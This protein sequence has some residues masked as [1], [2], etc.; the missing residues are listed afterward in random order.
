MKKVLTVSVLLMCHC[1]VFANEIRVISLDEFNGTIVPEIKKSEKLIRNLEME[2]EISG[3]QKPLNSASAD[4]KDSGFYAKVKLLSDGQQKG[5][6]KINVFNEKHGTR[7]I[8][9]KSYELSYNGKQGKKLFHGKSLKDKTLE[10]KEC[11]ILSSRS[12]TIKSEMAAG[13]YG[14]P[15]I[16]NFLAEGSNPSFS[17]Y[18]KMIMDP[19][20]EYSSEFSRNI[21][22]VK[23]ENTE[24][25]RIQI[26]GKGVVRT[27]YWLDPA[28]N[29]APLASETVQWNKSGKEMVTS[30]R[31]VL[32]FKKISDDIWFPVIVQMKGRGIRVESKKILSVSKVRVNMEDLKDDD[33]DLY[34]PDDYK[35][36][37]KTKKK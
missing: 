23:F 29:Y 28:R 35:I 14:K 9:E 15:F 22:L 21:H 34:V 26:E 17:G 32:K 2:F 31:K 37:D 20:V 1:V 5:K 8:N 7:A 18:L 13:L 27:T 16:L 6:I 33:F 19:K 12:D 36:I 10:V 11:T 25:I 24:C 30:S 3:Q 4:W